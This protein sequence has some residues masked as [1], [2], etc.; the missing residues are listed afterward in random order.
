MV[1]YP[2]GFGPVQSESESHRV[3]YG[4]PQYQSVSNQDSPD[5][6]IYCSLECP[7]FLYV[8][9]IVARS[10]ADRVPSSLQYVTLLFRELCEC[11]A[12][13]QAQSDWFLHLGRSWSIE[14]VFTV[15]HINLLISGK[16]EHLIL[17]SRPL[18]VSI[19]CTMRC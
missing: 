8:Y 5:I 18:P 14:L 1:C 10:H 4:I 15:S 6:E 19:R 7:E 2:T 9:T 12:F 11:P 17:M 16:R 13:L 3:C